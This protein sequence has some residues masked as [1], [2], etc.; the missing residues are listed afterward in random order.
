MNLV[1]LDN[2]NPEIF[3]DPNLSDADEAGALSTDLEPPSGRG[4][5]A[6]NLSWMKMEEPPFLWCW[7]SP[8]LG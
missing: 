3:P 8:T 4:L 5:P 2:Q 6:G 1:F 7:Y